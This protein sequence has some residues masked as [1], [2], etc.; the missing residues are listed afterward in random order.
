MSSNPLDILKKGLVNLQSQTKGTKSRLLTGL[1][2]HE[3]ITEEEEHWLD[4]DANLVEG[5]Q[6][7][8]ELEKASDYKQ[9]LGRLDEIKKKLLHAFLL[10]M[11]IW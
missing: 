8:G 3:I 9:G 1:A 7:I 11:E 4:H 5:E 10:L 6:V 2:N